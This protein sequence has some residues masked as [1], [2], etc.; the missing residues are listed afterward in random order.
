VKVKKNFQSLVKSVQV[1][2]VEEEGVGGSAVPPE[3]VVGLLGEEEVF[4]EEEGARGNVVPPEEV[5]VLLGE[6]EMFGEEEGVR[7]NV[8]SQ[9][10]SKRH[11]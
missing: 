2:N 7:G 4:G 5:V 9:E 10:L 8:V 3:E 1:R 6:E 11:L